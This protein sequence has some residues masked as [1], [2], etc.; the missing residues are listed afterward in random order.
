MDDLLGP[1]VAPPQKIGA[2]WV[3]QRRQSILD[4]TEGPHFRE[5]EKQR[6]GQVMDLRRLP[7]ELKEKLDREEEN[8]IPLAYL[9]KEIL[10]KAAHDSDRTVRVHT[11]RILGE[12]PELAGTFAEFVREAIKD[13]D[14]HVRRAAADTLGRHPDTANI[15][16]LL[17]LKA[18]TPADDTH[19][20]HVARM[21]LRDQLLG[22]ETWIW[23][24]KQSLTDA[25]LAGI[26]DVTTGVPTAAAAQFL[27]GHINKHQESPEN[28]IRYVHHIARYG[29]PAQGPKLLFF[30]QADKSSGILG[31]VALMKAY[32]QGIQERGG[33]L[34]A[35][36]RK[37]ALV[38][39]TAL[40]DSPHANEVLEGIGQAAAF[41]L[42]G[43]RDKLA[44]LASNGKAPEPNRL[45]ALSAL[46]AIEPK[47]AAPMLGKAL[48]DSSAPFGVR[49]RAASLLASGNQAEGQAELLKALP[50]APERL[51]N[52]IGAGLAARRPGA[53]ALLDA[54][55]AGKASARLLQDNR[56]AGLLANAKVPNLADRLATLLRGLPPADQRI[57]TLISKRCADFGAS[58][59]DA[60]MGSKVFETHCAACHQIGGKGAKIGPQLDGVGVRGSTGSSRTCSTRVGTLTR[61]SGPQRSP[62]RTAASFPA[63]CSATPA[64]SL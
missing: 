39:T 35:D 58:K 5:S 22:D 26:A 42:D 7:A 16:L 55:T 30:L 21:A 37:F 14:P 25:E 60:A 38:L 11:M 17:A 32:Q 27:F 34:S 31:Q 3:L 10:T 4:K 13:T 40:L 52:T 54:I 49:E 6:L 24:D 29:D 20:I 59:A 19:L 23:L 51:Q 18:S 46:S 62:S 64:R 56:I 44:A 47:S 45:E 36:D 2:L 61:P 1:E 63:F 50:T 43:V 15:K 33:Q 12:R 9:T 53:E 8:P 48:T 28:L 41:R 57:N